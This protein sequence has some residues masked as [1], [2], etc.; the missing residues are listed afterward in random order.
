[1]KQ[2]QHELDKKWLLSFRNEKKKFEGKTNLTEMEREHLAAVEKQIIIF[3]KKVNR[4]KVL[5]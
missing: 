4:N 1:M 3:E 2:T 5:C